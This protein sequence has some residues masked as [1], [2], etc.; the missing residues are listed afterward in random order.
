MQWYVLYK[1]DLLDISNSRLNIC[2]FTQVNPNIVAMSEGLEIPVFAAGLVGSQRM[3][4]KI[5]KRH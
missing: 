2:V 4:C 5:V 1:H 3:H